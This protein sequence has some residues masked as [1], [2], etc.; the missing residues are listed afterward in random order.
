MRSAIHSGC[1]T[2]LLACVTTPG[3]SSLPAGSFVVSQTWYSCS[4]RGLA[5]AGDGRRPAEDQRRRLLVRSGQP[6]PRARVGAGVDLQQDVYHLLQRRVV[7]AWALV[8]AVARVEAHLLGWDAL[9]AVVDRLH[10]GL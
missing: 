10:A 3:M 9:Q 5:A 4:W 7:H 2:M 1:S 6:A 8:D